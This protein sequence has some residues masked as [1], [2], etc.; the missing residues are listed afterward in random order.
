MMWWY[1]GQ[2]GWGMMLVN[3]LVA[4]IFLGGLVALVVWA[5]WALVGTP[6]RANQQPPAD[7]PLEV[8]RRRLA[9]GEISQEEYERTAGPWNRAREARS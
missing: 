6:S 3:A 7:R 5:I 8:L 9:A 1:P 2:I 4:L